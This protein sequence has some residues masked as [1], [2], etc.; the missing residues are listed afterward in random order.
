MKK[1]WRNPIEGKIEGCKPFRTTLTR[2]KEQVKTITSLSLQYTLN[3]SL[4]K[5]RLSLTRFRDRHVSKQIYVHMR[6]K[7]QFQVK[8]I[9]RDNMEK[10]W[11]YSSF[12]SMIKGYK[13]N[14]TQLYIV[15]NLFLGTSASSKTSKYSNV[16]QVSVPSR[17][18]HVRY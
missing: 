10:I 14:R 13:P 1:I 11:R 7:F 16:Q 15:S 9:L 17:K 4:Q 3:P 6:S 18:D 5:S 12:P 2:W 8:K